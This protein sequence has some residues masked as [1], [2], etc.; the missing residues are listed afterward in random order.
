MIIFWLGVGLVG[1]LCSVLCMSA[2][3][4]GTRSDKSYD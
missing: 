1:C 3:I 4:V 2:V